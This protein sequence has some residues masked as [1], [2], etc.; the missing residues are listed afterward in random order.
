MFRGRLTVLFQADDSAG[1][2]PP[3]ARKIPLDRKQLQ[4]A[5]AA[6][7]G[8]VAAGTGLSEELDKAAHGATVQEDPDALRRPGREGFEILATDV[9]D[10][11]AEAIDP[12]DL[13]GQGPALA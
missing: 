8:A 10:A 9:R 5:C 1:R 11:V 13:S 12:D 7:D 4:A 6:Q 3:L 2:N